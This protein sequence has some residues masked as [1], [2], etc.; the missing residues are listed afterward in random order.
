[1]E[2]SAP[3]HVKKGKATKTE[4]TTKI[5]L[6]KKMKKE[7]KKR[8]SNTKDKTKIETKIVTKNNNKKGPPRWGRQRNAKQKK[9]TT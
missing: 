7:E 9:H 2:Q 6:K 1:M 3:Q 5:I 8:R 4:H